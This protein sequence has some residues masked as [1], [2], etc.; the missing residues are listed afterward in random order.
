MKRNEHIKPDGAWMK[1]GA[2]LA[3]AGLLTYWL[4]KRETPK[5]ARPIRNAGP[6][7]MRTPPKRWDETDE[8]SDESFPAS[9]PPGTY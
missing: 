4:L 7:N 6:E 9:D 8:T 1:T 3:S 5:A 2:A